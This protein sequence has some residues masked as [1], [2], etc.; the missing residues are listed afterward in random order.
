[1]YKRVLVPVDGSE[2]AEAIIPFIL[3]IA[4]PLDL[5]VVLLRVNRPV[6]PVVLEASRH[7]EVEDVEANL[8]AAEAYLAGL[9]AEMQA[10]GVRATSRVRRGGDAASEILAAARDEQADLIAMST[11]GRTGPARLLFG[12][13]AEGVLRHATIPVFLMRQTER[14]IER[15]R[16]ATTAA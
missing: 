4:G 9:V 11:H 6:P 10:K 13:V 14:E 12:S 1:M 16:K 3:D 7:V 8:A 15:R 2:V 5:D